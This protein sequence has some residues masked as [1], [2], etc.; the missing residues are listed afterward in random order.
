MKR[1]DMKDLPATGFLRE[2]QVLAFIP[3]SRSAWWNGVKEGRYPAP[4]KLAPRTSAWRAEDI[5]ALIA[6]L[7]A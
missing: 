7:A 6:Q 3:V 5:R 4:V 1:E 2:K